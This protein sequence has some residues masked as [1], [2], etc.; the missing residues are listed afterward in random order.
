M[1]ILWFNLLVL[2]E[3]LVAF[4]N[5]FNLLENLFQVVAQLGHL[6]PRTQAYPAGLALTHDLPLPS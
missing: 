5:H 2:C 1:L 3:T 6:T 4:L